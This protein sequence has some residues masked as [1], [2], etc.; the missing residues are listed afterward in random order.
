MVT[1]TDIGYYLQNFAQYV[2]NRV[3]N[4]S[5]FLADHLKLRRYVGLSH[6]TLNLPNIRMNFFIRIIR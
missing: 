1:L 2:E 5:T 4:L 6:I 3:I